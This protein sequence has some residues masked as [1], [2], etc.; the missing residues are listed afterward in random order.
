SHL[1]TAV[2]P[3]SISDLA[4]ELLC[5]IFK[6]FCIHDA[7][8]R[9]SGMRVYT[10]TRIC[11]LWRTLSQNLPELW[12]SIYISRVQPLHAQMVDECLRRS[13]DLSLDVS[14]TMKETNG[15]WPILFLI[16]GS[17]GRIRSLALD[18]T[19]STFENLGLQVAPAYAPRLE[20]LELH[21]SGPETSSQQQFHSSIQLRH[22]P[23][24]KSLVLGGVGIQH[25]DPAEFVHKLEVL[26]LDAGAFVNDRGLPGLKILLSFWAVEEVRETSALRLLAIRGFAAELRPSPDEAVSFASFVSCVTSLFIGYRW[27]GPSVLAAFRCAP[28]RQITIL[29]EAPQFATD[30]AQQD[31]QF[32]TVTSLD[33][34]DSTAIPGLKNTLPAIS[35]LRIRGTVNLPDLES[36]STG[37]QW[38]DLRVL[39]V[40]AS[41]ISLKNLCAFVEARASASLPLAEVVYRMPKDSLFA[42]NLWTK[43]LKEHTDFR[44][45]RL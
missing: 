4:P 21:A 44:D 14:L 45:E 10:L 43:W 38:A 18:L 36:L 42:V 26:D 30:L 31:M 6:W 22:S 40:E 27:A 23:L 34:E 5:Q 11:G 35:R 28:L 19:R 37:N 2:K 15:M 25:P 9:P 41:G 33:I 16:W 39:I 12:T 24:L 13:K 17:V 29:D 1:F 8:Q 7:D 3:I 32:P 20:Y